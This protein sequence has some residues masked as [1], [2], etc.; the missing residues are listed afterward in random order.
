MKNNI[1]AYVVSGGYS[2]RFGTDKALYQYKGQSLI[3]YTL[4]LLSEEFDPV[5]IVAKNV[6]DYRWFGYEVIPDIVDQQSP[7]VGVISGMLNSNTEWVYFQ[8]CDMPFMTCGILG[9][10]LDYL[11]MVQES[12]GLQAVIPVTDFGLQPLAGFYH[13][14]T[15]DSLREAIHKNLSV[16]EWVDSLTVKTMNFGS[17]MSFRNVNEV[18][19][20]K[21][22]S[23]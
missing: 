1:S 7:L 2:R 18:E 12:S 15:I 4:D 20:L 13:K 10:L 8:A 17:A 6:E 5:S 11:K 9:I 23:V 3:K 19:D 22:V 21:V 16:T 14:N